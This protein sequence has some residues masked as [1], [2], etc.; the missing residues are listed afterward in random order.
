MA[1]QSRGPRAFSALSGSICLSCRSATQSLARPA[2]L[3][4]PS[5]STSSF[6]TTAARRA[7]DDPPTNQSPASV[8]SAALPAN[9]RPTGFNGFSAGGGFSD[10]LSNRT[11]VDYRPGEVAL[12][13]EPE[14]YHLHVLATKH[15]THMTLTRPDRN[16]IISVSAGNIGFRKAGRNS[17]DAAYQL[18]AFVLGN[19]QERGL[20]MEIKRLELVF[21]GFGDGREA[22]RKAIMGSEG[23]NIRNRI[24]RVTDATRLKFGGTRSPKPR[25]LG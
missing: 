13:E 19:I 5:T 22:V 21:R 8:L 11:G 17:F 12:T 16:A 15:N 20:L 2:F 7:D 3:A 24:V 25:R 4:R 18:A 6:S 23:M 9:R 1:F 10:M 14:P